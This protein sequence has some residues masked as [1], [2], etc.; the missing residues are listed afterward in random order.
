MN[1][2]EHAQRI[3]QN[4][5]KKSKEGENVSHLN[6]EVNPNTKD[7]KPINLKVSR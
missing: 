1:K 3:Q 2:M 4:G 6:M 5:Y 7:V